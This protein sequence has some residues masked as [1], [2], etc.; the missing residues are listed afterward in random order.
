[1]AALEAAAGLRTA[2]VVVA[3]GSAGVLGV[4]GWCGLSAPTPAVATVLPAAGADAAPEGLADEAAPSPSDTLS[5]GDGDDAI[6]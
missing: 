1:M 4:A 2:A 3:V 5:I 6:D